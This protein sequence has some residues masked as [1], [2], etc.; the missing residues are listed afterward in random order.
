MRTDELIRALGADARPRRLSVAATWRFALPAAAVLAALVFFA[1]IGPRPDIAAAMETAR[2]LFKFV[3]TAALAGAAFGAARMLGRPGA[4]SRTALAALLVAPALLA[5]GVLLELYVVP[6]AE[7]GARLIGSNS[8]TC[9]TFVPLIGIGPLAVFLAAL[10]ANAPTRPRLAGA[11]AGLLAGGLA[12]TFYAA[13]CTDDSPLFVA[14][15][16][17]LAIALLAAVGAAAGG[18]VLRW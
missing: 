8:R 9:L 15:W 17:T 16:Y 4:A 12:A 5:A 2:F 6:S 11:V 1:A 10:R 3:V 14:T 13:H 7:W 18:R